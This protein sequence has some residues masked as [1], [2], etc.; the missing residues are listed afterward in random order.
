[1]SSNRVWL[2]G[3]IIAP[4]R[5]NIRLCIKASA[6]NVPERMYT[7]GVAVDLGSDWRS[8][9]MLAL[10]SCLSVNQI[11]QASLKPKRSL[12]LAEDCQVPLEAL[13]L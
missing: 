9:N 13:C 12:Y 10:E 4:A 7:P 3:L 2:D 1:M 8:F 6:G 11:G 5:D